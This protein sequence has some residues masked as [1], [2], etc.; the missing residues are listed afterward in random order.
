M[1]IVG[2]KGFA[3]EI[4][5]I[6]HKNDQLKDLY[7]FDNI[8]KDKSH[9][10]GLFPILKSFSEAKTI[11]DNIDPEFT[12]GIGNPLLRKKM[13]SIFEQ[14]GGKFTSVISKNADI[15]NYGV[16]IGQGCNI[17]PTALIANGSTLGKGCIVYYNVTITHDCVIGDF[18]EL[19]PGATILGEVE[20]GENCQIGANVTIL[21]KIKI[22]I[23]AI[24][25]AGAVVTKNLPDNCV[26][27][28]IPAKIIK[29]I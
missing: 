23:N 26:A 10:Y 21:P 6:L 13:L 18:V 3:K 24:V 22:G 19:S 25:G 15:G 20:I 1:L 7:F 2:A 9:V 4:L 28:G 29:Y 16:K 8:N 27:V 11:F 5:E 12:I 17:L 14:L